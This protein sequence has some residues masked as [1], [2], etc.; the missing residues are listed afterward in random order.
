[1][2]SSSAR[3]TGSGGRSPRSAACSGA[4]RAPALH[5]PGG[6]GEAPVLVLERQVRVVGGVGGEALAPAPL[7]VGDL[8]GEARALDVVGTAR[9]ALAVA[10]LRPRRPDGAEAALAHPEAEV[11]VVEPDRQVLLVEPADGLERVAPDHEARRGDGRELLD[12]ARPPAVADRPA[13]AAAVH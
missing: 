13:R 5:D 7:H 2:W 1:M 11:D 8:S 6:K 12:G 10:E 3:C 4:V 9:G